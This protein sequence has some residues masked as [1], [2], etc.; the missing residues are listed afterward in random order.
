M[1]QS[2]KNVCAKFKVDP[3]NRFCN[4]ARQVFTTQKLFPSEIPLTM[5]IATTNSD[6]ITSVKFLLKS[7]TSNKSVPEQKSKYLS[8]IMV[9]PFFHLIFLLE[10]NKQEIFKRRH[11]KDQKCF[12]VNFAKFPRAPF[13]NRTPPVSATEK[14]TIV[15]P[16]T[17]QRTLFTQVTGNWVSDHYARKSI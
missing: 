4:E 12:P 14:W 7:L 6:Q 2:V 16:I 8:S 13:S 3:L 11:E 15:K 9:F 10:W 17:L 5:K 1:Q